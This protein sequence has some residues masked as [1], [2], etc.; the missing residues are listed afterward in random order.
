VD[1]Q[2]YIKGRIVEVYEKLVVV[3]EWQ[4]K[5]QLLVDKSRVQCLEEQDSCEISS[6]PSNHTAFRDSPD[7]TDLP[8]AM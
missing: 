2:R 5:S 1:S 7:D 8:I 3:E 6:V 4:C